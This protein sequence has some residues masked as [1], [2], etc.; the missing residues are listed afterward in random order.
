MTNDIE[1]AIEEALSLKNLPGRSHRMMSVFHAMPYMS[2]GIL[3]PATTPEG[4]LVELCKEF[5]AI[6]VY[7]SN[8]ATVN[9]ITS[10]FIIAPVIFSQYYEGNIYIE[11]FRVPMFKK[12]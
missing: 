11:C 10:Q 5:N 8:Q 1:R 9:S 12:A 2:Y 7:S 4:A 3:I 6:M